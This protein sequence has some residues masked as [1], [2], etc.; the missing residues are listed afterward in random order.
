MPSEALKLHTPPTPAPEVAAEATRQNFE[1]V[2]DWPADTG[3]LID[4][5]ELARRLCV[6]VSTLDRLRAA[7]KVGPRAIKCGGV[8]FLL[9]EVIAWLSTPTPAGELYDAA[10]WPAVWAAM[11]KRAGTP[12]R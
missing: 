11:Q 6:G 1:R 7:G 2:T 8:R 12:G 10:T 4:R 9:A 5:D 3:R